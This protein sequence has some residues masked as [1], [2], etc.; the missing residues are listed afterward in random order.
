VESRKTPGFLGGAV[1]RWRGIPEL[2]LAAL[3]AVWCLIA[4]LSRPRAATV[5]P[6]DRA[7]ESGVLVAEPEPPRRR[8]TRSPKT[9]VRIPHA[10]RR[11]EPMA[12]TAGI[13]RA[14]PLNEADAARHLAR[15]LHRVVGSRASETAVAVLWAHWAHETGRGKRMLG[16]NFAGIKG[17]GTQGGARVWTR[18]SDGSKKELVRRTFRFYE[19]PEQGALDYVTLLRTRYRGALSAAREDRIADFVN[20]L[21]VR[22]Y[23]TDDKGVYERAITRLALECRRRSLARRALDDER[24]RGTCVCHDTPVKSRREPWLGL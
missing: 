19:S 4:F 12:T 21:L 5:G 9:A 1:P 7:P 18:E 6:G 16:H 14:T 11:V 15:A 20:L 13:I 17:E 10:W 3:F 24:N 23:Y 2:R 22:G 8:I